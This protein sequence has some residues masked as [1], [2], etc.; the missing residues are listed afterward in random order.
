[1]AFQ[2]ARGELEKIPQT[3]KTGVKAKEKRLWL[4]ATRA[5]AKTQTVR[6]KV[7]YLPRRSPRFLSKKKK[8]EKIF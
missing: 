2:C 5:V 3:I 7:E 1:M 6:L 4:F 8:C